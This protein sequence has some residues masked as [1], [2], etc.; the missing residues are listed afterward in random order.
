[1]FG[2]KITTYRKLA[3]A[4]L[5]QLQVFFPKMAG[6][7]T[8]TE[9]L[10]GAENLNHL[11]DLVFEIQHQIA[12]VPLQLAQRWANAYGTRVWR[13]LNQ[14]NSLHD[15][16]CDFGYGLYAKEVDYLVEVEWGMCSDDILW[17]RSKLGLLF[18]Q[19]EIANLDEYLVKLQRLRAR[20]DAA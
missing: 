12:D 14:A 3:E 9:V 16:G 18:S 11:E 7:W 13:M 20:E 2:G 15:L 4:A 6:A 17:R 5:E 8:A 1:M 10:P 19:S